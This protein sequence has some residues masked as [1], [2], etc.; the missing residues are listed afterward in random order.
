[1]NKKRKGFPAFTLIEMMVSLTLFAIAMLAIVNLLTTSVRLMETMSGAD[2]SKTQALLLS[3]IMENTAR[4]SYAV[5]QYT[6]G[7]LLLTDFSQFR[8]QFTT[9]GKAVFFDKYGKQGLISRKIFVLD[10]ANAIEI[11]MMKNSGRQAISL[12]ID[13]PD[14]DIKKIMLLGYQKGE[15]PQ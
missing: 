4:D 10:N 9:M 6:N 8:N 1:M 2:D 11:K 5:Q 14:Q 3:R 7:S 13:L 12:Y 15:T